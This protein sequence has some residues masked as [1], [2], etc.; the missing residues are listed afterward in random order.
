VA[1]GPIKSVSDLFGNDAPLRYIADKHFPDDCYERY[2]LLKAADSYGQLAMYHFDLRQTQEHIELIRSI[3][4]PDEKAVLQLAVRLQYA[5]E[6]VQSTDPKV[7]EDGAAAIK[8]ASELMHIW[9]RLYLNLDRLLKISAN[10]LFLGDRP[11]GS[12]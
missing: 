9:Y 3:G 7:A 2:V 12:A 4:F 6:R 5:T 10:F 8:Q 11:E 1:D